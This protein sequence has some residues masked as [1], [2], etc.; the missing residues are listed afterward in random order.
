MEQILNIYLYSNNFNKETI[1]YDYFLSGLFN[2]R[3]H[4]ERDID[5]IL[6]K[7]KNPEAS[8]VVFIG[9]TNSLNEQV[10]TL[11]LS[12][13]NLPILI[14]D[15][16]LSN[17]VQ[18]IEEKYSN[19]IPFN[20][21]APLGELKNK[22]C[23]KLE[24]DQWKDSNHT[25]FIRFKK[26]IFDLFDE[27]PCDVYLKI[28]DNKYLKVYKENSSNQ[29]TSMNNENKNIEHLFI[30][31]DQCEAF[32]TRLIE[33]IDEI[34]KNGNYSDLLPMYCQ[35]TVFEL[36]RQIGLTEELLEVSN[37]AIDSALKLIEQNHNIKEMWQNIVKK[38]DFLA[39]HS[40][41]VTHIASAILEYTPWRSETNVVKL[42]VASFFHDMQIRERK[43]I[44]EH[45]LVKDNEGSRT[46]K[47]DMMKH[48]YRAVEMLSQISNMPIDVDSIIKNHHECYDGNGYPKGADFSKLSALPTVFILAHDLVNHLYTTGFSEKNIQNFVNGVKNIYTEDYFK[49]VLHGI[50]LAF[51]LK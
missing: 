4:K 27:K 19:I 38:Q 48:P 42:A 7:I 46:D 26:K 44:L 18:K 15:K 11:K 35:D 39:E 2:G 33:A 16:N 17:K 12:H 21:S 49:T 32:I 40:L 1:F 36:L 34:S 10:C 51:K 14:L 30:N 23:E 43:Q 22:I 24:I 45:D 20:T 41:L 50:S 29:L 6:S 37:W 8:L 31:I 13:K 25:Q 9:T 47:L 5:I 3:T 28:S